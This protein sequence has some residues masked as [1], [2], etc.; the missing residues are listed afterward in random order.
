MKLTLKNHYFIRADSIVMY[1]HSTFFGKHSD[2][3]IYRLHKK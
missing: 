1:E 2:F 3:F